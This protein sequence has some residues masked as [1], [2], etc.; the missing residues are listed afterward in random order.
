M[1]SPEQAAELAKEVYLVV[2]E[3]TD[4]FELAHVGADLA[5]LLGAILCDTQCEWPADR[6]LLEIL[7][8]ELPASR[9]WDH[10]VIAT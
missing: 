8:K 4:S 1:L 3:H 2:F 10:I 9:C 7:R 5:Y 6:P